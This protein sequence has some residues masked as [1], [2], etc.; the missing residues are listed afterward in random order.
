VTLRL[1][2]ITGTPAPLQAA[3]GHHFVHANTGSPAD[4]T[5]APQN[6]KGP[7]VNNLNISG[8]L[9]QQATFHTNN[10]KPRANFTLAVDNGNNPTSFIPITCFGRTAQLVAEHTDK[11]HLIS[12]EGRLTSGKYANNA[13]ETIYT[14]DVIANRI[15]FLSRPK[16]S[17]TTPEP[18]D[19]NDDTEAV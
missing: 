12:V 16:T 1:P 10:D 14:L 17:T 11:G 13:G 5:P 7:A 15:E 4:A 18:V 19:T 8:R 2:D 3:A 9:V 6:P